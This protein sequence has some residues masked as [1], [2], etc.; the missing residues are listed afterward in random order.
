MDDA[1]SDGGYDAEPEGNHNRH[2]SLDANPR[3]PPSLTHSSSIPPPLYVTQLAI[4]QRVQT[5]RKV[6]DDQPD[7]HDLNWYVQV[8]LVQVLLAVASLGCVVLRW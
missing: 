5:I 2:A 3:S 4:V 7:W 1:S 6:W 8:L